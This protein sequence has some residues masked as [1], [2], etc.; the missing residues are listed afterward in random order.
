MLSE[1]RNVLHVTQIYAMH[2]KGWIWH[3]RDITVGYSKKNEV[4][5]GEETPKCLASCNIN[6][7][8]RAG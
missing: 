3:N 5:K 6:W 4:Q 2:T 8:Q 1:T 7:K